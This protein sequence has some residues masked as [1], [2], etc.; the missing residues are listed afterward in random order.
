MMII[1][2]IVSY[3]LYLYF[4]SRNKIERTSSTTVLDKASFERSFNMSYDEC[5]R[6]GIIRE[7]YQK[8]KYFYIAV[9]F[10]L[11]FFVFLGLCFL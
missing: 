11:A 2:A 1:C 6:A 8:T 9:F 3:V 4:W 10:G 7:H 5:L